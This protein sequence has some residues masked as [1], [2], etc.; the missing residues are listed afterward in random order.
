[1]SI[2]MGKWVLALDGADLPE[3]NLIGGKA[4][5]IAKMANLGLNVPP[6]MVITTKACAAYLK[7]GDLPDGL[8]GEI[9]KGIKWLE[10]KTN[11][12][13]G[14]APNPLLVSV[15]SGA[16]I[17]MPGMMDTVLNLGIN[18]DIEAAL[19]SECNDP[20]FARNTHKRFI[21]LYANIVLKS[22][23]EE[24]DENGTP[25]SWKQKINKDTGKEVPDQVSDQLLG[26]VKA[27]FESWNT[28]RAKRY[29]KHHNIPDTLGTAVTIQAMV[30]GNM[31]DQSGTGVLFTR[32]PL[33]GD[34]EPYG[35]YLTRAQGEDIVSGKHTPLQLDAMKASVADAHTRL[36]EAAA[37]LEKQER[38]VQDIEFTIEKGLLYMLQ[39]RSAKR[40]PA[41][42]VRIAVD[43]MEEGLISGE[44]AVSRVTAEQV[45]TLLNPVLPASTI[46]GATVLAFGKGASPGVGIGVIVTD[47]NATEKRAALG[48]DVI[49]VRPTT[50][51]NDIHGMIAAKAIATEHGGSTSH[52]AVVGR[53]LG[54]PCIV[55]CG[56]D[57]LMALAGKTVTLDGTSGQIYDGALDVI[58]PIETGDPILSKLLA[59]AKE[60]CPIKVLAH[61][62]DQSNVTDLDSSH[63]I[64]DPEHL[65]EHIRAM[66]DVKILKTDTQLN[67]ACV[68]AAMYAGVE[69]II[70]S[71]TL[72]VMLSAIHSKADRHA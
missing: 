38:D 32:N 17:S 5:S 67:D 56:A 23:L 64:E 8:A 26:A 63:D 35:E 50:S 72:P 49:L 59:K 2:S 16:A 51:P 6:A 13:F 70:A 18:S 33:S 71:P 15:R 40:A 53:A 29:R 1:M 14:S 11:R 7:S 36:L 27:V 69:T 52:A 66:T 65:P 44:E 12:S 60:L 20:D 48:E 55:G 3:K 21:D 30:F 31:D 42:A 41:A 10:E 62:D 46:E 34:P 57:S 68:A 25:E 39:S 58:V 19:G 22:T 37:I 43:M 4:W 61:A 45:R 47:T 9:F 54:R 28:R 24:F